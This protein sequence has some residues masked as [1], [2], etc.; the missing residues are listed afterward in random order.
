MESENFAIFPLEVTKDQLCD[1]LRPFK[2]L[3]TIYL[4][5]ERFESLKINQR[6]SLLTLTFRIIYYKDSGF[7][8]FLLKAL[9]ILNY[10]KDRKAVC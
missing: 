6:G 8:L 7:N 4:K 3:R 5:F 10:W 9:K 1:K 2:D